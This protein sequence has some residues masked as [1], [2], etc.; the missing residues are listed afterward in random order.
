MQV[1]STVAV[2]IWTSAS[3]R[4]LS[5]RA[6]PI[7]ANIKEWLI[8]LGIGSSPNQKLTLAKG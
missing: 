3:Y 2:E 8:E 6:L 7:G 1:Q 4:R 5:P